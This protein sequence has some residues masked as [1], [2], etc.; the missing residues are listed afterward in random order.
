MPTRI[1]VDNLALYPAHNL[2]VEEYVFTGDGFCNHNKATLIQ[3]SLRAAITSGSLV[4]LST[5][6]YLEI[7]V[8]HND[9]I[10]LRVTIKDGGVSS[11]VL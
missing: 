4:M 5:D 8:K 6:S 3:D 1:V 9:L 2:S 7:T 10:S 11:T